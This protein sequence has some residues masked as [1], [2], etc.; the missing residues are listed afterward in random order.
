MFACISR[1]LWPGRT[2]GV[3]PSTITSVESTVSYSESTVILDVDLGELVSDRTSVSLEERLDSLE[4]DDIA[5]PSVTPHH[6]PTASAMKSVEVEQ[7][8]CSPDPPRAKINKPHR[9]ELPDCDPPIATGYDSA[10]D[11]LH[12]ELSRVACL[13]KAYVIRRAAA[14]ELCPL[15]VVTQVPFS[16]GHGPA[17]AHWHRSWIDQLDAAQALH[18][19]ISSR[20]ALT[21]RESLGRF[22]LFRL[23]QIFRE[24]TR[25]WV[26]H[27][28]SE[29]DPAHLFELQRDILLVAF[30][31]YHFATFRNAFSKL[32]TDDGAAPNGLSAGMAVEICQPRPARGENTLALFLRDVP[33]L[34]DRY[35][36]MGDTRID[37]SRRRL[38]IDPMIA[39]FLLGENDNDPELLGFVTRVAGSFPWEHL[40]A[41]ESTLNHLKSL[42][43]RMPSNAVVLFHGPAGGPFV[44]AA[45]AVLSGRRHP[46]LLVADV[47]GAP[48]LP[49]WVEWTTRVQRQARLQGS[50]ILWKG[51]TAIVEASRTDGRWQQLVQ[52]HPD[53][54]VFIATDVAWD[55][56]GTFGRRD[57][58]FVRVEFPI[59]GREIRQQI[60][61][62]ELEHASIHLAPFGP[63]LELLASFQF[64]EGQVADSIMIAR[65]LALTSATQPPDMAAMLY[66]ACRRVSARGLVSFTQRIPPRKF[67]NVKNP[68]D[69][70]ILA[71]E[72]KQ[73]LQELDDRIQNMNRVYYEYGFS[74]N[75]CL[76][77]GLIALFSGPSGTGKTL[78]ATALAS[79]RERDLYKVDMSAV[80]S[81]Y[82]GETEKNLARVF[83]DAQSAN[84]LLFFDEADAIF[85]K[86]GDI[87]KAQDRWANMEINYLLQRVEE[88]SG[89]V[90][91]AT[92]LKQNIDEAFLRRVQV[93]IDF[94]PPDALSRRTILKEMF[95]SDVIPPSDDELKAY[96]EQF[97]L[98]GG[99]LKNVAVDAAF[100]AFH[101][102]G[103][104]KPGESHAKLRVGIE[105]LVLATAREYR[106][107][108]RPVTLA[109]FGRNFYGMTKTLNLN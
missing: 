92:N 32:T 50:A 17:A 80:V 44:S 95:P 30:L 42:S 94:K 63:A 49:G 108:S 6:L 69:A 3:G 96:C 102:P 81:K 106:K 91:L 11:Y 74:S 58:T 23:L 38:Q 62:T 64:T 21:P 78:A 16:W 22:P 65:G 48:S 34:S 60:W 19:W 36:D 103:A 93:L 15:D 20:L 61:H 99:N 98:T 86:R 107:L 2:Q 33:L 35:V 46:S 47:A 8:S 1:T 40:L 88:F 83:S 89:V 67:G 101:D 66:D 27:H 37:V 26:R 55:P 10:L 7:P 105:H 73:Q 53:T 71:P 72:S 82:V 4:V 52:T 54:P 59:P 100:R 45:R 104:P 70:V 79:G 97:E 87:D 13:V 76:G 43:H 31:D 28:S 24:D 85:G 14:Q 68:L 9:Q 39:G 90:I 12:D 109:S 57:S 51:A 84:A 75:L 29:A 56:E 25:T 18:E 77:R 5:S 41:D